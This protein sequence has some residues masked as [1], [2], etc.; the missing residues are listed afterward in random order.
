[1]KTWAPFRVRTNT[2]TRSTL[3]EVCVVDL[4]IPRRVEL[5][6]WAAGAGRARCTPCADCHRT[7]SA[8]TLQPR[9]QG[10]ERAGTLSPLAI[11]FGADSEPLADVGAVLEALNLL[12]SAA[13]T[14][15][16]ATPARNTGPFFR[17]ANC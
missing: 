1:M 15:A 7:P 9:L 5:D 16:T 12:V 17:R 4:L 10:G 3:G 13:A 6:R 14:L 8:S 2:R 11:D